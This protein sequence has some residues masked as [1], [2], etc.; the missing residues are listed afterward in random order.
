MKTKPCPKCGSRI[1]VF[2]ESEDPRETVFVARCTKCSWGV[3]LREVSEV[4]LWFE[5][6]RANSQEPVE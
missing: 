2:N 4:K 3:T 5:S 1:D 6:E